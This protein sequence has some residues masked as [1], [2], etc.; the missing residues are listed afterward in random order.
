MVVLLFSSPVLRLTIKVRANCAAPVQTLWRNRGDSF[1][2]VSQSC[3]TFYRCAMR[4]WQRLFLAFALLSGA[5][6]LGF[7]LWQQQSFRRG[8]LGYLDT[9]ALARLS[10]AATRLSAAYEENGNWD[11]LRDDP[12]RFGELIEPRAEHPHPPDHGPPIGEHPPGGAFG[13]SGHP[14]PPHGPPDLMPRVLLVDAAGKRIAGNEFVPSTVASIPLTV[15]GHLIG[16]LRLAPAPQLSDATDVAFAQTQTRSALVAGVATLI[17]A[18]LLAFALAR[19]LLAPVR[20]LADGTRALA[21][22]DY[23]RRIDTQR[24]DELGALAHDFNHLAASLEQN[25]TARRQWGADIAHELRTPLSILRGE[26]QALQDGVRAP[27]AQ[28]LESL[29]SECERLGALIEDLYQLSLADAGALEYRFEAIDATQI[30]CDAAA[31]QRAV[32]ADAGL[33]L[34]TSL[35]AALIVRADARRLAQLVDNLLANARR[36]TDA[37]GT[38]RISL[39]R[40]GDDAELTVEDSAPGVPESAL[41]RLFERLYRV[42]SSRSRAQGGAGLGLAICRAIVDA[43]GGKIHAQPSSLGGLRVVVRL[44]LQP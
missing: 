3:A 19:W 39:A 10:P 16:T 6:L 11:F 43:H 42:D 35:G 38:I 31:A 27:S 8:F 41:P 29:H 23:A 18:L 7:A 14:P 34:E 24:G 21:A 20:A 4:L 22:G 32:C 25:R 9:V 13:E 44:P 36:Y 17:A 2:M 26:I 28:A 40:D 33:A 15:D 37:P 5:V 12:R 1:A 30:V